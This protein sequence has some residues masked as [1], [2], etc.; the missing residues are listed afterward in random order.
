GD[1]VNLHP[2]PSQGD[3]VNLHPTYR[4]GGGATTKGDLVN[5]HPIGNDPAT[6][7]TAFLRRLTHH[8][9]ADL[10]DAVLDVGVAAADAWEETWTTVCIGFAKM[11]G[12]GEY[13]SNQAQ[14]FAEEKG[15]K[16]NTKYHEDYARFRVHEHYTEAQRTRYLRNF[17]Y[18]QGAKLVDA[19]WHIGQASADAFDRTCHALMEVEAR[20]VHACVV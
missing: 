3:L 4:D 8:Q 14:A 9:A 12:I 18:A 11:F 13:G 15:T 10:V 2:T 5:L 6:D 19:T 7:Q 17:S 1:L 16:N 20:A